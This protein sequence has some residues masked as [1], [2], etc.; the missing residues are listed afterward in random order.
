MAN[1]AVANLIA[2][3]KSNLIYSAMESGTQQGMQTMEHSLA[4][5]YLRGDI[6]EQTVNALARKPAQVFERASR[7]RTRAT[8][9]A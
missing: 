4:T 2:T 1:Q 6:S 8:E 7:M 5:L 9:T 3:G